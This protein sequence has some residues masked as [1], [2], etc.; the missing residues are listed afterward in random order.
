VTLNKATNH[1][2]SFQQINLFKKG[3]EGGETSRNRSPG[4]PYPLFPRR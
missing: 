4:A 2:S 1:R 3:R